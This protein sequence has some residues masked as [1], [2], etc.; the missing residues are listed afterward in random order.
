MGE[1][2]E[3]TAVKGGVRVAIHVQPRASR[4]EIAGLHGTALK[5]RLHSPPVDGAAND[6][7]VDLLASELGITK[8]AVTIVSGHASRGKMVQL[9]GVSA[10]RVQALAEGADGNSGA[11]SP[12]RSR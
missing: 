2:L 9:D 8:R 11:R 1:K 5:V 10:A 3:V 4:T 7:L 12:S 6:E